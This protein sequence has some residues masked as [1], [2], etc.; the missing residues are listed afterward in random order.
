MATAM[1]STLASAD[2]LH[3]AR[4]AALSVEVQPEQ[5]GSLLAEKQ[6]QRD[7]LSQEVSR[8]SQIVFL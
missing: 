8:C 7:Q 2:G 3:A 6:S 5:L 1:M 4:H